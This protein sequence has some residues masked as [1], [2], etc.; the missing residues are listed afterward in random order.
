M[1]KM[2]C[3]FL[4]LALIISLTP[5][6]FAAESSNA[7]PILIAT[8]D[9]LIAVAQEI[10]KSGNGGKGRLYRLTENIDLKGEVWFDSIGSKDIPFSGT[11]D[12]NGKIIS[13][14][15]IPTYASQSYVGTGLFGTIGGNAVIKNLGLERITVFGKDSY[16]WDVYA[17]GLAGE[18]V[19]N[20]GID[21]V[22]VRNIT[23]DT[24]PVHIGIGGG[25]LGRANGEGVTIT[26][27]YCVN[28]S[29][30][31][32]C[33]ATEA[34]V[35]GRLETFAKLANCYSTANLAT[36][37][38]ENHAVSVENS[39]CINHNW[40]ANIN[41]AAG[42]QITDAQLK[43]KYTDLGSAFKKGIPAYGGYPALVWE[44]APEEL[45]G[46]GTESDPF[47]IK[48][49]FHLIEMSTAENTDGVYYQLANDIDLEHA[50][51]SNFIGSYSSPFMGIFDGNGH[52]IKNY[53]LIAPP[54]DQ[55]DEWQI[56]AGI[57]GY[58]S[59][60]A[61]IKNLGVENVVFN[62]ATNNYRECIGS[63]VGIADGNAT[64]SGCYAKN[65]VNADLNSPEIMAAGA[66]I[67]AT[68]NSGV[69]VE[70]CYSIGVDFKDSTID[71]D[72]GIVGAGIAF[73]TMKNCYSTATVSRVDNVSYHERVKNCYYV[74]AAPWPADKYV[75]TSVTV[76]ELSGMA[77][78]LGAAFKPGSYATGGMPALT[79]QPDAESSG[80]T[81]TKDDPMIIK[82]AQDLIC[83]ANLENTAGMYFRLENDIDL[84]DSEWL[85]AIGSSETPFCG[86]FDGNGHTV[87]HYKLVAAGNRI[88]GLF[89][90]VGGNAVITNLG[91]KN[92]KAILTNAQSWNS[93]CGGMI[94]LIQDNAVLM[95]CF[96]KDV[97]FSL[98][99]N[100]TW[101]GEFEY[102][103]GVIGRING[104]GVEIRNCYSKGFTQTYDDNGVNMPPVNND[105]GFAG[106]GACFAV[107]SNCYSDTTMFRAP[108]WLTNENCYQGQIAKEWPGGYEWD[109]DVV[110]DITGIAYKLGK[111]FAGVD[112]EAPILRWELGNGLYKN[113]VSNG[114]FSDT[115]LSAFEAPG[116]TIVLNKNG[117]ISKMGHIN[118]GATILAKAAVKR[119]SYYR[120]SIRTS[121]AS[122]EGAFDM[123]V[124]GTD[125]TAHLKDNRINTAWETQTSII[126]ADADELTLTFKPGVETYI[127][128]VE[129]MEVDVDTEEKMIKESIRANYQK[130]SYVDDR[131]AIDLSVNDGLPLTYE[132]EHGYIDANGYLTDLVPTGFG[133]TEERYTG[134]YAYADR[135]VSNSFTVTV[136]EREPIAIKEVN[137]YD[138]DG[139]KIYGMAKAKRIGNVVLEINAEKDAKVVASLYKNGVMT[140]VKVV[141]VEESGVCEINM[142]VEGNDTYKMFVMTNN[143]LAPLA[144]P[145]QPYK[146]LSTDDKVKILTIGDSIA[147][148]YDPN[149]TVLRGWGQM[150][151]NQYTANVTVD[152]SLSLGGMTAYN[153]LFNGRFDT[154][155][156]RMN[157]GDYV[158]IQLCTNDRVQN[159]T[160]EEFKQFLTQFVLMIRDRGGYPV[161]ITSPEESECATN[162]KGADGKFKINPVH[163]G[164]PDVMRNISKERNVPLIDLNKETQRLMATL[165]LDAI[166]ALNYWTDDTIHFT[167]AGA[168]YLADFIAKESARIGLP[169][170]EF[171]KNK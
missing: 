138:N 37:A 121:A 153:F 70:N 129:I 54:S 1:K 124:N 165:G 118:G 158:Y 6:V 142:D 8:A 150:L 58:I 161:L 5:A 32:D 131:V 100:R 105:G 48:N 2:I 139:N 97:D 130:N 157:V 122:T 30:M 35:V 109:A 107:V 28:F 132:S 69:N 86:V 81:G 11:F 127:D 89:G 85:T 126:K 13:N 68:V 83:V 102:G 134:S 94:G 55:I 7:D 60:N 26:N 141:P 96:A 16:G 163:Q 76:S 80:G 72:A 113:L 66:I 160:K 31:N 167:E 125:F 82:T 147:A 74:S 98:T 137:L 77:N 57:F 53:K 21:N 92:V 170:G 59:K 19:G 148:T 135:T 52:I 43:D 29:E 99:F 149:A 75:G 116:L 171:V 78:T 155:L 136:K 50:G 144:I 88:Y 14:F 79:W 166:L 33:C 133:M 108:A 49:I 38:A 159:F 9:E 119:G 168:N 44:S 146:S 84:N 152:N 143:T 93:T 18:A 24:L 101:E 4:S 115:D 12:G 91:V 51:F 169:I 162:E 112:N 3:I 87:S 17:G 156:E 151:G 39:Y 95:N 123:S 145:A 128:D 164:Y 111:E 34:G 41:I 120:I 25:I 46:S 64:I 65:I 71:C 63:I 27:S 114:S 117:R 36:Y 22:F 56:A 47:L 61:V 15:K 110:S 10:N 103:G 67:A 20:A 106:E 73:G 62:S 154:L 104:S 140:A 23:F 40:Y 45:S 42:K 90:V